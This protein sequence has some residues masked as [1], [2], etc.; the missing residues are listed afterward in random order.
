[1]ENREHP[2][3]NRLISSQEEMKRGDSRVTS[4]YLKGLWWEISALVTDPVW[5][6]VGK[7]YR[8]RT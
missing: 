1:M 7:R 4:S 2:P 8:F 5:R 3:I 6:A